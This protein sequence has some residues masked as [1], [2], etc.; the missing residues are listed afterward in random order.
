[1]PVVSAPEAA[2]PVEETWRV[3]RIMAEFVEAFEKLAN[4][5]PAVS[6]FGS[7][8]FR[9]SNPYYRLTRRTAKLFAQNGLAVI[10]GGGPGVMEAANRGAIEA[11]G[12]SVGLNIALPQE[13]EANPYQ[14]IAMH[15][16][17]FFARKVMFIKY[18][19]AFVIFPGG[20]GTMD[21]FFES[22]TLIQTMKIRRFPVVAM[23][24]KFWEPLREFLQTR[25]YRQF[26]TISKEDLNF[27]AMTDD[28]EEA[29]A[30]VQKCR[31]DR[32]WDR[33][34][35]DAILTPMKEFPSGA[36]QVGDY[37]LFPDA[38]AVSPEGTLRGRAPHYH[39]RKPK[40]ASR[41][42]RADR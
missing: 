12:K 6:I 33:Q 14:N 41:K 38:G 31:Q 34:T 36:G 20:Y 26:K 24:T 28:P 16:H 40:A 8:R 5:G 23:G 39:P 19:Q 9:P 2:G 11:G 18:A 13:Q 7:A 1:M 21:E 30:I 15:F 10:T 17:Y 27:F 29:L 42:P 35:G 3:F 32:C 4:L 25:M 37:C 22:M